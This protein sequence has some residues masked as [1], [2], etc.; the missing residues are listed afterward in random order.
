MRITPQPDDRSH[1]PPR[2][3]GRGGAAR[4]RHAAALVAALLHSTPA[5]AQNPELPN[6]SFNGFGTMGVAHLD[7]DK[8]DFVRSPV[9]PDGAGF[10]RNPSPEVDS[11]LGL[12]LISDLTPNL[13]A[14]GQVVIEQGADENYDPQVEWANLA[15]DVN[16]SLDV[17]F[18][19]IPLPIFLVSQYRK[20]GL[21]NPWVRPPQ[22]VYNLVPVTSIDGLSLGY[23][24]RGKAGI[25]TLRVSVGQSEEDVPDAPPF[26]ARDALMVLNVFERGALTLYGGY[27]TAR[28]KWDGLDSLTDGFRQFGPEGEAIAER[29]DVDGQRID[30]AALGSRYDPGSWFLMG[31]WARVKS[32]AFFG[33]SRG[34]YFTGGYRLGSLT[35]YVTV[36]DI[37]HLSATSDPG[38]TLTGLPPAMAAQGR[39]LNQTLNST[40]GNVPD[41]TRL[42]LGLRWDITPATALKVQYDHVDLDDDSPGFLTNEQRGFERGSTVSVLSLTLDFVF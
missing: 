6:V 5:T 19:R 35:P 34:W 21:A 2:S 31:E 38:L 13:S 39:I 24:I 9:A 23:R 30:V 7:T 17:R 42:G 15:Y 4:A 25:N 32:R 1:A 20:V 37:K 28:L 36:A 16:P 8:A 26:I 27:Y 3:R 22:E 10:T 40:L 41:Q 29:Y 14:F 12:Q 18:G 33:D 11:R